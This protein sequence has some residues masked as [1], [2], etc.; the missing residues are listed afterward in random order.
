MRFLTVSLVMLIAVLVA[1]PGCEPR[2]AGEDAAQREPAEVIPDP[3]PQPIYDLIVL[4]ILDTS[5]S[6]A[7]YLERKGHPF[8]MHTIDTL[9]RNRMGS[10]DRL[11]LGQISGTRTAL[12]WDGNPKSLRIDYADQKKFTKFLMSR[13]DPGGSR[14]YDSISDGLEYL[15]HYPGAREKKTKVCAVILTDMDDNVNDESQ[16]KSKARLLKSLTEFGKLDSCMGIY[17]CEPQFVNTWRDQLRQCGVRGVVHS[18]IVADPP[19]PTF[20]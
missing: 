5:G 16:E 17:W 19:L 15:I 9:F 11:V 6:Y 18:G 7:G 3:I 12:F 10:N 20:E 13:P 4:I 14:V 8:C 2:K 1:V